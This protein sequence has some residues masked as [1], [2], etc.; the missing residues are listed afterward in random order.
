MQVTPLAGW[1]FSRRPAACSAR[2]RESQGMPIGPWPG[3]GVAFAWALAALGVG[4]A[5]SCAPR[6][7]I[8]RASR[9]IHNCPVPPWRYDRSNRRPTRTPASGPG[10]FAELYRRD[11][12]SVTTGASTPRLCGSRPDRRDVR[13]S[14]NEPP[15]L[16]RR[17]GRINA[18]GLLGIARNVLRESAGA[19]GS[20]RRDRPRGN[21]RCSW[22]AHRRRA[23]TT[24]RHATRPRWSASAQAP[25]RT[26]R[27]RIRGR[28]PGV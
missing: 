12:A 2:S 18:P 21:A 20:F 1:R 28:S 8:A 11:A 10:A 9:W 22:T 25:L 24:T 15:S 7:L 5:V 6:R 13:A 17:A 27:V 16:S 3:L 26:R 14:L 23:S 4:Y 19:I